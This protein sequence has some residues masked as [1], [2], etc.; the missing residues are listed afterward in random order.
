MLFNKSRSIRAAGEIAACLAVSIVVSATFGCGGRTPSGLNENENL[1]EWRDGGPPDGSPHDGWTPDGAPP[2]GSPYPDA[3]GT[4]FGYVKVRHQASPGR[5]GGSHLSL[6]ASYYTEQHDPDDPDPS[7]L[8]GYQGTMT[9]PNG[10]S[11]DIFFVQGMDPPEPPPEPEQVNAG[12]IT[13]VRSDWPED[14]DALMVEFINGEYEPDRRSVNDPQ[15]PFPAWFVAEPMDLVFTVGGHSEIPGSEEEVA[16]GAMPHITIPSGGEP[17]PLDFNGNYHIAWDETGANRTRVV[18]N[19]NLDWDNSSFVCRPPVGTTELLIPQD[20]IDEY[21]W[22]SG[23]LVV[24]GI[25]EVERVDWLSVVTKLRAARA[26]QRYVHF[27]QY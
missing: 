4:V 19:F 26:A 14:M 27:T 23:Q 15:N 20:W 3:G 10:V 24:V 12:T 8:P 21:T 25:N 22:G 7:Q 1:N 18:F 16:M 2:D 17:A 13:V 6:T 9:T 11:C 5:V